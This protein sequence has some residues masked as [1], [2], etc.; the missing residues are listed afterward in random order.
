[1]PVFN[2]HEYLYSSISSILDQTYTKFE[3]IIAD[4]GSTDKSGEIIDSFIDERII[5]YKNLI[6]KGISKT[7][8]D[9]INLARGDY[10]I[11]VD[12]DD[13]NDPERLIQQYRFMESNKNIDICGTWIQYLGTKTLIDYPTQDHMIKVQLLEGPAMVHPSLMIRAESVKKY[14][15]RYNESIEVAVDYELYAKYSTILTYANIPKVLYYLREHEFRISNRMNNLRIQNHKR[16]QNYILNL[17]LTKYS[18]M[19]WQIHLYLMDP[20]N[21]QKTF[22]FDLV[23]N[24]IR[25]LVESNNKEYRYNST[26]LSNYLNKKFEVLIKMRFDEQFIFAQDYSINLFKE[27]FFSSYKPYRFYKL[28]IRLKI[29]LKC[30]LNYK[31]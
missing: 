26:S 10:L 3:L 19:D 28:A 17:L 29:V 15:I 6:R 9:L 31:K 14:G 5:K 1:M 11:I 23:E 8:N 25:R 4:D 27:F 22:E 30:I 7:R 18:R 12:S 2:S 21:S 24:W 16:I 13:I 20:L